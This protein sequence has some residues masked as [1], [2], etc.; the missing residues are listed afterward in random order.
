MKILM[1][2]LAVANSAIVISSLWTQSVDEYTLLY[3]FLAGITS[4]ILIDLLNIR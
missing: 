4:G 1:I 2:F 3:A